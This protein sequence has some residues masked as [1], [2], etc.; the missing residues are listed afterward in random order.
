V[1]TLEKALRDSRS[2]PLAVGAD[3]LYSSRLN[4]KGAIHTAV[5]EFELA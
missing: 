5:R 1:E 2:A 3:T 4:P